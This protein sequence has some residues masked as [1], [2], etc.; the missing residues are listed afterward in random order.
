M[1]LGYS[2]GQKN[3][4]KYYFITL[5][6]NGVRDEIVSDLF[7]ISVEEYIDILHAAG[8]YAEDD[9]GYI[10]NSEEEVV[11]SI[12]MLKVLLYEP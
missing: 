3:S 1:K 4:K 2:S 11:N 8:G 6:N 10:F 12:V 9:R 5:N 7:H